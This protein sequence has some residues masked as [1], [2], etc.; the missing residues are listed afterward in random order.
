MM[1]AQGQTS[2]RTAYEQA[3]DGSAVVLIHGLGLSRRMW[4]WQAPVLSEHFRIV[5]YD[6]IGHGESDK[7]AGPYAMSD[8][9]AQL[10]EV[11]DS[12]GLDDFA[13]VGFSLGGLIA[14]AF[15]LAYPDRVRA[16]GILHSAYDRSAAERAAIRARVLLADEQGPKAGVE[17]ALERWFTPGFAA[18]C[19]E[20]LQEVREWIEAND[21]NA[22]AAAYDVLAEADTELAHALA[23][24]RCPALVMTGSEDHG[25]SPQMAA[26]MAARMPNAECR[27]LPGLRHMALAEDPQSTLSQLLPF[28]ANTLTPGS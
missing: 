10:R 8:F 21:P 7:P 23:D 16:V 24:I 19:P 26:R 2:A 17:S 4:Q 1:S 14:Q 5:R 11:V 27:I 3:G 25:N 12:V 6:L 9:V 20:R 22:F 18:R 28:L 13:L 15:T